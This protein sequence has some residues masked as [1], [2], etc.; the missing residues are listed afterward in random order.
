MITGPHAEELKQELNYLLNDMK[1]REQDLVISV[2]GLEGSGKSRWA[3]NLAVLLD[4]EFT[5]ETLRQKTAQTVEDFGRLAPKTKPF[6]VCLWD[7][8]HR[9]S[10]R[11]TYD[12]DVNRDLLEYF[13]DIRGA[14][15]IFILCYPDIEEIDR[16]IIKRSRLFFETVK[17]GDTFSVRVWKKQQI[18]NKIRELRLPSPD[19][20]RKLWVGVSQFPKAIYGHDTENIEGVLETYK[21][22]K[23]S[24]LRLTDQKL[25]EK[26]GYRNAMQ[27]AIIVQQVIE[28]LGICGLSFNWIQQ[29][30]SNKLKQNE[31]KWDTHMIGG[32]WRIYKDEVYE[33]CIFEVLKDIRLANPKISIIIK[34]TQ[35]LNY[36]QDILNKENKDEI[37]VSTQ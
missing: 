32:V 15:K 7:E 30:V 2:Y 11:G 6:N 37:K 18:E 35:D 27:T 16:K 9:F 21:E 25:A 19:T 17:Q 28:D 5:G 10:K 33:N 14:K 22:F 31:D 36:N 26:Y 1:K 8:A 12:T 20:R 34:D 29:L 13:Q 4:K 24:G 23:G 3:M